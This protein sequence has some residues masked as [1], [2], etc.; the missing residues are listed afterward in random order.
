MTMYSIGLMSGTSMDGVDA[1]L[2][3]TDGSPQ[4][5]NPIG[6]ISLRYS[7]ACRLLFKAAEYAVR[8]L[9][10]DEARA[11]AHFEDLLWEFF[12]H[13]LNLPQEAWERQYQTLA[14]ALGALIEERYGREVIT[15]KAIIELSTRYHIQ[16]VQRLLA[17]LRLS[18]SD[19]DVIGYHGQCLYHQPARQISVIV[20]DGQMMA[21]ALQI[22]VV[23]DFRRN[24][25]EHGGQG[26]PFAPL[27]HQALAIRDQRLPL[28]VVNCG[29][30][31]NVTFVLGEHGSDLIAFDTGPGNALIDQLMRQRTQGEQHYDRDGVHAL[32]GK[33]NTPVLA[34]LFE[35]AVQKHNDN[36][37]LMSPPK[38]LDYGDLKLI[39][40]LDT[41]DLPDAC[42]TL[43]AFTAQTIV[44]SLDWISEPYPHHW[45]L[46]GGG[47]NNPVILSE[48]KTRLAARL[49][50]TDQLITIQT[51][52]DIGWNNQ[53]LEAQIFAYLAV[54]RLN[55]LPLSYPKTTG[56]SMPVTGGEIYHF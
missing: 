9:D 4:L 12:E 25:M 18:A 13:A 33:V 50:N 55:E 53:A 35:S 34:Q 10:G 41:L 21:E 19:I 49:A 56:V 3:Q 30:I 29:G 43:A 31:S 23:N 20:G 42:R 7:P 52:D 54:R 39:P 45:V 2:I 37:L 16:A 46:A 48:F 14:A 40:A 38:S 6:H 24:D 26:A 22:R 47:W 44:N 28:A 51:A 17:Q 32:Q 15:L 27:Y 8:R 1:A 5:L 11:H 36:Y